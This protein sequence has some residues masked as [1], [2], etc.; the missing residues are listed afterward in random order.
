MEGPVLLAPSPP[1]PRPELVFS[2]CLDSLRTLGCCHLDTC[3]PTL[4][5]PA[6]LANPRRPVP[7]LFHLKKWVLVCSLGAYIPARSAW[8]LVTADQCPHPVP[9]SGPETPSLSVPTSPVPE[10]S[11]KSRILPAPKLGRALLDPTEA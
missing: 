11:R 4:A 2:A 7:Q 6:T 8:G 3:S 9:N 1:S 5:P 10:A